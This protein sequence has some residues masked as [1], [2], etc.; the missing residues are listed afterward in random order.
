MLQ[1]LRRPVRWEE[2]QNTLRL[3]HRVGWR[4]V[5]Q[6]GGL[7]PPPT[8]IT[9]EE[10]LSFLHKGLPPH[11]ATLIRFRFYHL[12]RAE[13]DGGLYAPFATLFNPVV[14]VTRPGPHRFE[15]WRGVLGPLFDVDAAGWCCESLV[16]RTLTPL[17]D[18]AG[19]VYGR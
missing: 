3:R 9:L 19:C 15:A 10:L 18:T 16:D 5:L 12:D 7:S 14:C 2:R 1:E 17:C 4:S 8:V 13:M 11:R 6:M